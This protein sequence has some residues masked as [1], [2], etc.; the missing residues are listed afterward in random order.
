MSEKHS[1][2]AEI[3]EVLSLIINTIYSNE[4]IFLR[5][6]VSNA[7]DALNKLKSA[8]SNE[9]H[10]IVIECNAESKTLS[11]IDNGVGMTKQELIENLGTIAHSGTKKFLDSL[12]Q[13]D[14]FIGNF[15]VGFFS[16]YLV[17][18]KVTV[19][20][21]HNNDD[22]YQWESSADGTFIISKVED[23]SISRGTRVVLHMKD[24][25]YLDEFK[26]KSIVK[27]HLDFVEFP[28]IMCNKVLNHQNASW[29]HDPKDVLDSEYLALYRSLSQTTNETFLVKTHFKIEGAIELKG[30]M[31][32]PKS[33]PYDM[34]EHKA[35]HYKNVKLYTRRI[36][37]TDES[38]YVIPEYL[39]FVTGVID[40][41]DFPLNISR[42]RLK[43][44]KILKVVKKQVVKK[45]IEMMTELAQNDTAYEEFYDK[46]C[47]CLKLG[48]YEDD[49]NRE[50][51]AEL[52]RFSTTTKTK[53]NM[54]SFKQ[55]V[56]RM[57]KTQENIYY[58]AGE[59]EENLRESPFLEQYHAQDYEVLLMTDVMD[60]YAM[61][62][63]EE[64]AGKKVINISNHQL[65]N[66]TSL[67]NAVILCD[68]MKKILGDKVQSV[69]ESNIVVTSP[70]VLVASKNSMSANM[71][72]IIKSQALCSSSLKSNM[73]SKKCLEINPSHS[74]IQKLSET[75][76]S[77]GDFEKYVTVLFDI[78]LLTSGYSLENPSQVGR[79]LYDL[80]DSELHRQ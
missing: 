78:A 75:S 1:F 6:L 54:T 10:E 2:E 18:E 48:L 45:S 57:K 42:E 72:R 47:H 56:N 77:D 59:T 68:K 60:E 49:D 71:E 46:Y 3:N 31:Y 15:G 28:I 50:K 30:I 35:R 58:I 25:V 33:P 64:Y 13:T 12:K 23:T 11:V 73:T 16:S 63:M 22:T 8:E 65:Q 7:S 69:Y 4:D 14:A 32:I 66:S 70:C 39:S 36:F 5:E 26:I 51:L 67:G 43:D 37:I 74:L 24:H 76:F 19:I 27:K 61:Q 80:L 17:A 21:K 40:S 62:K 52:L 53:T 79:N 29:L 9:N 20:T 55:Y 44:S 34:F 41:I 38:E